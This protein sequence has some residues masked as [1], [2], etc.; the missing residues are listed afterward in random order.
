VPEDQ[1]PEEA[2][3][4]VRR[5]RELAEERPDATAYVHLAMDGTEPSVTWAELHRR[6]SQVAAALAAHGVGFGD[7]VGLG[8]RNSPE[9]VFAV[10]ATWKLG[11][12]PIPVRWDVPDWEL[13]RLKE[14]IEPKLYVS[15]DD[16]PWIEASAD[17]PVPDLPEVLSPYSNGIC[18]SGATGTPKVI[19]S[20]AAPVFNP[21]MSVPIA[22][23][24][25]T[26]TRPQRILVPAPMYHINAFA[27]LSSMLTGDVL[28]V[29]PKFDAARIVDVIERYRITT[30]TGTPTMLQRIAD[31]PGVDDRDL[32]SIEWIMIGA[33][34]I[35][36]SLVHR[37]A[38]LI[39]A[40]KIVMA[41]GSTEGLGLTVITGD[42]W[43]QHEGSVG[44]GFRGAEV[45]ILD[46]EQRDLPLGETGNVYVRSPNYNGA[47]YL[48]KAPQIPMTEDGF[49]TV[50]DMGYLDADGYLYLVDR[51]VDL[52]I[53]G[54]ANV[55]PA[56]VEAALIDH[57]KIAD[58]V[59]IGLKDPEWG[60]RVHAVIEPA[61]PADPPTFDEIK[62]YV[63][64]R[65]LPYKVPKSIELVDGIPRSEAMKVNRGRLV[66][67]R[68]G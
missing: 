59:V 14:V 3:S 29:L 43:L 17:D 61:D 49:G 31:V 53:T 7:R 32:S 40:E 24:F 23:N 11:A 34:P 66:E 35:A 54:G 1:V 60:R 64:S 33:A 12:V 16:L 63:K 58:V 52:I 55:F 15:P 46:D 2:A 39:G 37:W 27:T 22:E 45:R 48:G 36:P 67:A 8:I 68:G 41:Y 47:L 42:E 51:R 26:I 56:E 9:F 50:G 44:R 6:S 30:F 19:L 18:S 65:L 21:T 13:A 4:N 5:V 25:M 20:Q 38:K 28:H 57:P 62:A 10:I